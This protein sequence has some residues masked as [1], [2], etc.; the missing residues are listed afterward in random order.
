ML[1]IVEVERQL[2]LSG[3]MND[4]NFQPNKIRCQSK[5]YIT[6]KL[7]QNTI[8]TFIQPHSTPLVLLLYCSLWIH[9]KYF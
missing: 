2:C 1:T 7:V 3:K 8:R 4:L 9:V 5:N 6:L